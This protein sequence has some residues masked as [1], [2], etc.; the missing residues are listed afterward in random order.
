MTDYTIACGCGR[1][2][3]PDGRA[4]RGAFRCGCGTRI[5]VVE[6]QTP[7]ARC[8]AASCRAASVTGAVIR[9]CVDHKDEATMMLAQ[10]VA[11]TDLKN[12]GRLVEEGATK[13]REPVIPVYCGPETEVTEAAI[14]REITGPGRHEPV[15]YFLR[16]SER[17]KIGYTTNLFE[18]IT[19]LSLRRSDVLLLVDG[20]R[21][22]ETDMHRRFH[23]YRIAGTEW[24]A[25]KGELRTFI[26]SRPR[27]PEGR[28]PRKLA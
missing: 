13:W 9:L 7:S 27:R 14:I 26:E 17:V 24:F 12:L 2:M 1:S 18:R 10:D 22:M 5:R 4:G 6:Q 19:A 28:H 8:S 23:G 16:N 21:R 15:V 11:R 3:N 25:L 20:G